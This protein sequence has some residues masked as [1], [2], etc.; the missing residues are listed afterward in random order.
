VGDL[1]TELAAL[2]QAFLP[3]I[4]F[5]IGPPSNEPAQRARDAAVAQA[6]KLLALPATEPAQ[7]DAQEFA[8]THGYRGYCHETKQAAHLC[9]AA[10]AQP[11]TAEGAEGDGG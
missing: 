2:R 3:L 7:P 11:D 10:P 9:G 8:C 1:L 6:R 5:A 4:S